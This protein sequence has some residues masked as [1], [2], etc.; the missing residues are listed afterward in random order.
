MKILYVTRHF[1]HSGYLILQRLI[2]E[3]IPISAIL[4]HADKDP[5][6][7]PVRGAWLRLVYRV[8]CWYYRCKPLRTMA[9][10]E[11]LAKRHGIPRIYADSIKSDAFQVQ[12]EQLAPDL[13]VL[14]GGWHEL[15]PER[16]FNLPPLGCINTHPS[17]LPAFRG[18]SITRWQVLHGVASSGSTI[19]YVDDRFDTGGALAQRAVPV[20]EDL[21]PQ[22]LFHLLGEVGADIMPEL[23]RAFQQSGKQPT[24][25]TQ[26]EER[27]CKYFKRWTWSEA[28]LRI[29]W[30][31]SFRDIHFFVLANTQES[32]EYLGPHFTIGGSRYFLRRTRLIHDPGAARTNVSSSYGPIRC[33]EHSDGSWRLSRANDPDALELIQVQRFDERYRWRRASAACRILPPLANGTFTPDA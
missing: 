32:Y 25:A 7:T 30:S 18:T 21:T 9:S 28:A 3:G 4:L 23:L 19:H 20:G 26:A 1:N 16:V 5:W 17:L 10:E 6:R 15:I 29:D 12:L 8:K 2:A 33:E 27:H 13:I 14:G 24:F 22:E 31:R 11:A